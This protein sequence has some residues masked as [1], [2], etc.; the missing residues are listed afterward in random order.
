MFV[1]RVAPEQLGF[2][3]LSEHSLNQPVALVDQ[4][5]KSFHSEICS[6]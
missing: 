6:P 1:P 4:K 3:E 5:K 2:V